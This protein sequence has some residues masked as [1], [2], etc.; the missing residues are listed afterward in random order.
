MAMAALRRYKRLCLML[1]LVYSGERRACQGNGSCGG[2]LSSRRIHKLEESHRKV[3]ETRKE[4]FHRIC[5][6]AVSSTVDVRDMLNQQ[7]ATEKQQNHDCLLK[8]LSTV[9][10][11]A[12]QGLTLCGDEDESNSNLHQLLCLR[13]EDDPALIS[14]LKKKQLKYTSHDMQNELISI[15]AQQMVRETVAQLQSAV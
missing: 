6:E 15:M 9:R 1:H 5:F 14:F 4:R 13:G 8:I 12:R 7:A 3:R 10:F 11:L 2:K